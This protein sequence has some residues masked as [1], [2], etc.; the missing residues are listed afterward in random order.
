MSLIKI[1]PTGNMTIGF[2][3]VVVVCQLGKSLVILVL[4]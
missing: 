4:I 1:S 2:G 3:T